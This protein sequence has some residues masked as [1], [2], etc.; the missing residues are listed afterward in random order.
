MTY[1]AIQVMDKSDSNSLTTE[2]RER[3]IDELLAL[4]EKGDPSLTEADYERI[5]SY[6]FDRR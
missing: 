1:Q 3:D 5:D 4:A 6:Q 2:P